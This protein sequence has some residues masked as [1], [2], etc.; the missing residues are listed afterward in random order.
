MF[1]PH[2]DLV[3]N[4]S[5]LAPWQKLEV[6]RTYLLLSLSYNK[7]SEKIVTTFLKELDRSYLIFL[8]NVAEV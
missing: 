4:A 2:T 1:R 7:G 3:E 5:L 6:D 8:R